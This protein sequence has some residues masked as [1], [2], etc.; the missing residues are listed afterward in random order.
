MF[1][2]VDSVRARQIFFKPIVCAS[3]LSQR[4]LRAA[5]IRPVVL[6][7]AASSVGPDLLAAISLI[8]LG[9]LA[10]ERRCLLLS[11]IASIF[12]AT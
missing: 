4:R 9:A 5:P 1:I 7:P 2:E 11:F 10:A 12:P 6:R 3:I 8:Q